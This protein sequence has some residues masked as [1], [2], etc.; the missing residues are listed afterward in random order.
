MPKI[1]KKQTALGTKYVLHHLYFSIGTKIMEIKPTWPFAGAGWQFFSPGLDEVAARQNGD[2]PEEIDP[3]SNYES[4]HLAP[5]RQITGNHKNSK[6][7]WS[8]F[9]Q[10]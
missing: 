9:E 7:K 10:A 6:Q 5:P 2:N 1:G 3:E 8:A 4:C